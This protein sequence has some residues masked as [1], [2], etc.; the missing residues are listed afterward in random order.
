MKRLQVLWQRYWHYV[1]VAFF[2]VILTV[3]VWGG[4]SGFMI[5]D[6]ANFHILRL[7]SVVHGL[8]DGQ[9][10]PQ[11]DPTI[12]NGYG[13]S[14]NL[15]YGPL[16]GYIAT[17]LRLVIHSWPIVFNLI[18]ILMMVFSGILMCYAV[19]KISKKQ[20]LGA[21]V[22]VLYMAAPYH[23]L[24]LSIRAAVG[25]LMA[26]MIAPLLI[27][28]LYQ[29]VNEQK[30]TVRNL[31]IAATVMLLSHNLSTLLFAIMAVVYLAINW[32]SLKKWQPWKNMLIA[33]GIIVG[34]TAFFTLPMLEA[35]FGGTYGIF[36]AEYADKYMVVNANQL[37]QSWIHPAKLLL[38][39]YNFGESYG[40]FD[41]LSNIRVGL[42]AVVGL[43]GF[44]FIFR[45]IHERSERKFV[46][47]LYTIAVLALLV[48][49][50]V[51][52]WEMMPS[53]LYS[54]QFVWR[55]LGIFITTMSIV[56]G[57][58]VYD[59]LK[60]MEEH[61]QQMLVLLVGLVAVWQVADIIVYRPQRHREADVVIDS[62]ANNGSIGWGAEYLPIQL[63]CENAVNKPDDVELN[64]N[65]TAAYS[66]TQK[67]GEKI[68]ILAGGAKIDKVSHDGTKWQFEVSEVEGETLI[69]LPLIWY[70]GYQA[71]LNGKKVKVEAS[72]ANGLVTVAINEPGEVR[73]RYGMSAMTKLG[74]AISGLT[75]LGLI[76][77]W[78]YPH[79]KKSYKC[80]Q[81]S[82]KS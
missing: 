51:R 41:T 13:Y 48:M 2:G 66:Y 20:V 60:E 16:L 50:G 70:P 46:V 49:I 32:Q 15:F 65:L 26:L 5:G 56:T 11:L 8:K 54:L 72:E 24:D 27:L 21:L 29:L 80:H 76:G 62:S 4:I 74:V 43:L 6:D 75:V 78:A 64:C 63:S 30:G 73:L 47:S 59:F 69:E 68:E 39:N 42:I 40:I 67:R 37:N 53:I 25:E 3:G 22:G 55:L 81:A 31:V 61:R 10:L 71:Q 9:I 17:A 58:V 38:D 19:T 12:L 57:Y 36:D 35:K 7:Q 33:G 18:L 1:V 77:W 52:K 34:L 23:A 45:R 28:G 44:W 79:L 82:K 14:Y